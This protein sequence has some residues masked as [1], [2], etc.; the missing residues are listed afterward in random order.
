[1][2]TKNAEKIKISIGYTYLSFFSGAQSE[3]KYSI[4]KYRE[5]CLYFS[6][7]LILAVTAE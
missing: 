3:Q 6:A 1:M 5:H 4:V 2:R 7:Q